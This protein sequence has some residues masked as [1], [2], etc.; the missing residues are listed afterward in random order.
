MTLRYSQSGAALVIALVFLLMLT[1]LGLSSSQVSIQQERMAG[2]YHQ[3]HLAF[4]DAEA[5]LRFIEEQ[6]RIKADGGVAN[7]A[8]EP[9]RWGDG[10]VNLNF[11]GD[12]T[13]ESTTGGD[14]SS[15]S[16]QSGGDDG[17]P[18]FTLALT[19]FTAPSGEDFGAPCRPVGSMVYPDGTP[20]P[21]EFHL[22]IVRGTGSDTNRPAEAMAQSIFYREPGP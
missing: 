1:I 9:P 2:N 21:P 8:G 20:V 17:V 6:L 22:V 14:W 3:A 4:Q 7:L 12:C 15:L 5:N 19:S 16:W 10:D 18:Y 11:R 13:L